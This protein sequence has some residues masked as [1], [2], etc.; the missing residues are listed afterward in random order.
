M[1]FYHESGRLK[2]TGT[3]SWSHSNTA[4]R[5]IYSTAIVSLVLHRKHAFWPRATSEV[6]LR[7][8]RYTTW[9]PRY[10]LACSDNTE[11]SG[12]RDTERD[13]QRDFLVLN[14]TGW[15]R[16][17]RIIQPFKR[18]TVTRSAENQSRQFLLLWCCSESGFTT[19]HQKLSGNNFAFQQDGAPQRQFIV[20]DKQLRFLRL[21]VPEFVEPENWPPHNPDLNPVDYSIW[22]VLQQLVYHRRRIRDVE[23][24]KEVL[25]TLI[26]VGCTC[27]LSLSFWMESMWWWWWNPPGADWSR[28]CYRSRY[29]TVS[30]TIV[31]RCCNRWRTHWAPLWLMFLVLLHVH[32]HTYV[33]CCRNT[34]LGQQKWIVRFILRHPVDTTMLQYIRVGVYAVASTSV[35]RLSS[36]RAVLGI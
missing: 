13:G 27:A 5:C 34:E 22:G 11:A 3:A 17:N 1:K 4:G 6:I 30:Q 15:R 18:K 31:A 32:H 28:R 35:I 10:R 26:S 8:V 9:H 12:Q 33:F 16:I 20:R 14:N 19:R 25:Q 21:H 7:T 23:H 24:M 2:R 36:E 29:R